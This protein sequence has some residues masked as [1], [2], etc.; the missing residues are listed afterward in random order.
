[1]TMWKCT[2]CGLIYDGEK[3]PEKCPKCGSPAEKFEKVSA[4]AEALLKKSRITNNLHIKITEK[5]TKII[6]SAEKGIDENLDPGCVAIFE[7][8][9]RDSYEINQ[10]IKAELQIH[11]NKGK[12]G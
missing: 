9:K 12:W 10:M 5:L 6:Q 2:V 7:R 3:P 4:D 8:V 11:M 1:M